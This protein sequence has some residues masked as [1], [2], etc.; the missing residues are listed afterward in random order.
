MDTKV[1]PGVLEK[2]IFVETLEKHLKLLTDPKYFE[3]YSYETWSLEYLIQ[4]YLGVQEGNNES[5]MNQA[6]DFL[7]SSEATYGYLNLLIKELEK[8]LQPLHPENSRPR[9][10]KNFIGV[11]YKD[12][13]N[14]RNSA[15][16]GSPSWQEVA[17]VNKFKPVTVLYLLRQMLEVDWLD[18][19]VHEKPV[20]S[21]PKRIES[22]EQIVVESIS[23]SVWNM[24]S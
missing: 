9:T 2:W 4:N 7:P 6:E 18:Y 14:L 8:D 16:D 23:L 13:G 24:T 5:L 21:I 1:P 15:I 22:K 3:R 10:H 19:S 20:H 17:S 12:K 11:G